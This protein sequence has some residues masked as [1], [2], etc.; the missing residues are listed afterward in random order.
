MDSLAS[1][2]RVPPTCLS[3]RAPALADVLGC[4]LGLGGIPGKLVGKLQ[5]GAVFLFQKRFMSTATGAVKTIAVQDLDQLDFSYLVEDDDNEK[6][7]E[8]SPPGD[9]ETEEVPGASAQQPGKKRAA[10]RDKK[11]TGHK[12]KK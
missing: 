5:H 2:Q 3:S 12:Q 7:Q 1:A 8:A 10:V 4:H 6:A 11:V 9:A